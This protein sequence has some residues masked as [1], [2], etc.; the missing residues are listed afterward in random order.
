MRVDLED[1]CEGLHI[2]LLLTVETA[3][4]KL[5]IFFLLLS[6]FYIMP[7]RIPYYFK[8]PFLKVIN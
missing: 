4:A 1:S 6:L 2:R 3:L 5:L 8:D 7:Y